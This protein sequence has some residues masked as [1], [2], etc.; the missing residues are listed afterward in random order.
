MKPDR[1]PGCNAELLR[2]GYEQ[3]RRDG[4]KRLVSEVGLGYAGIVIGLEVSRLAETPPIGTGC[5][6]YAL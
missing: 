1:F 4:F 6:R 5:W 3:L 2:S